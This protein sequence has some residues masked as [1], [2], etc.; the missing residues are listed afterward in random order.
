MPFSK[1]HP[2]VAAYFERIAA[3]ASFQR[4]IAEARPYF[5]Y[6]PFNDAIPARF[7]T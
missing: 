7:K 2:N 4:T 6:Y 5:Q 3:R 1:T